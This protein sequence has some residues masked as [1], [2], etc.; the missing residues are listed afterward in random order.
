MATIFHPKGGG[1]PS[2]TGLLRGAGYTMQVKKA[3]R[4]GDH[5]VLYGKSDSSPSEGPCLQEVD[6]GRRLLFMR[7]HT[8]AHLFDGVLKATTGTSYE[9]LDS[10]LGDET[11]VA[12]RGDRPSDEALKSA[13]ALA[14]RTIAEGRP[15]EAVVVRADE[16]QG[17][18]H[19][20]ESVLQDL[21]EVRL[22]R[23]VGFDPIPCGGTHVRDLKEVGGVKVIGVEDT[24]EG[25]KVLFDVFQPV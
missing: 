14:N 10:W 15:I 1:Q 16:L 13:E 5:V 12:Y 25:F 6:G 11:Y 7:R 21:S 9:P 18:R 20:W 22:V 3:L 19:F 17:M 24:P 4:A 2:D 8:A 23:I